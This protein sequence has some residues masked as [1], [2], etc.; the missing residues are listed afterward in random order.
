VVIKDIYQ[1]QV[2]DH[3]QAVASYECVKGIA[4]YCFSTDICTP[5]AQLLIFH[6][7]SLEA[8]IDWK[9]YYFPG[10]ATA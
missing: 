10:Y 1:Q 9:R 3:H 2:A 4:L 5:A 8:G 6:N 7:P